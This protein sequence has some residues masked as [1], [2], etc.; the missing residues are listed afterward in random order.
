M[1]WY[2]FALVDALPATRAGQ[3]LT[4]PL[5][6]RKLAGAFAVVERR[7]DVPPV[8]FGSLKKHQ[9][10][11]ARL[12]RQEKGKFSVGG[13]ISKLQAVK[14]AVSSGIRTHIASGRKPGQIARIVAGHAVG[15]RFVAKGEELGKRRRDT[16]R[17]RK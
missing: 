11:V 10:V 7:A 6:I 17:S 1:A 8:E 12:A 14:L 16:K 13:M 3:G 4:G 9:E 2:V 15:T 5:S